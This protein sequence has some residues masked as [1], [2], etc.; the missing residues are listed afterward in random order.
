[1][2]VVHNFF[3]V[4]NRHLR[5]ILTFIKCLKAQLK[6]NPTW[7]IMGKLIVCRPNFFHDSSKIVIGN[8][9]QAQ[10]DPSWNTFGI[11]QPNILNVRT[12]G[13]EIIIGENVGISGSTISAMKS[14][15]IG[16]NVLIGSG[17]IIC[18]NDAHP[19]IPT[20]RNNTKKIK[21]IPIVIEDDVFI[22]ARCIVLKGV[23]IGRGS[24]VGAGS[25][26]SKNIPSHELWAGNPAKFIKKIEEN[27]FPILKQ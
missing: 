25:V 19:I 26:V 20:D 8:Y 2:R 5:S 12:S 22:G 13:A 7:R 14:I 9:F 3:R 24:V 23:N 21:A 27:N 11:I 1:M 18:D 6:Y 15:R 4:I 16:N 17:C 10:A